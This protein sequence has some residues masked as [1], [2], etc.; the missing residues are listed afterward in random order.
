MQT[1][2]KNQLAVS[3]F[4]LRDSCK[5]E[6]GFRETLKKVRDIGYTAVEVAGFPPD[7]N[8]AAV[9]KALDDAGLVCSS[10]HENPTLILD[11]PAQVIENLN[12][13][14]CKYTAYP[15]P[16]GVVFD[17]PASMDKL[18][19]GLDSAGAVFAKAGI[20]LCYHNHAHELFRIGDSNVLAEIYRRV[21]ATHLS[22]QLDT[23]WIQAGG[24]NVATWIKSMS[25][26]L[27]LLHLKDYGV[28]P[29]GERHFAEIGS[30]S[31]D[32]KTLIP[33]AAEAGCKW[34]IVEQ[35]VCPGDPFV[36]IKKSYDYLVKNILG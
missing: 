21:P 30:G 32:W 14:G 17:D 25:G 12:T 2:K 27:P 28:N 22:A 5:N 6:A 20:T 4:T 31:L 11:N 34:V 24:A 18:V 16:A 8:A 33:L 7:M 1:M 9:R 26:R 3:L 15:Y 19:A 36:S 23:F 29:K 13:L 10:T 35:D